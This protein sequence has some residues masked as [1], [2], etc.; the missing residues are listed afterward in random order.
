MLASSLLGDTFCLCDIRT[1]RTQ[2]FYHSISQLRQMAKSKSKSK[3]KCAGTTHDT[4]VAVKR[5][6]TVADLRKHERLWY[7]ILLLIYD[8]HHQKQE[9]SK[10]R[11]DE[12]ID[13]IYIG[14]PYFTTEEADTIK[15][16][17]VDDTQSQTLEA[18]IQATLEE[19][20]QTTITHIFPC[21]PHD[22]VPVYLSCFS[23][24]KAEITD[25]KFVS[26]VARCGLQ[27]D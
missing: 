9:S 26:R 17:F 11:T 1:L 8:F 10:S 20:Q 15:M 21:G 19:R 27:V 13:P 24:D 12:I 3:G 4:N 18:L 25:T 14:M 22:M 16:A 23:I 6:L 5:F 2:P 7:K